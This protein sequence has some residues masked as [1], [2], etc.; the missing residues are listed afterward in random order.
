[1]AKDADVAAELLKAG[2]EYLRGAGAVE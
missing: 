1:V 2:D